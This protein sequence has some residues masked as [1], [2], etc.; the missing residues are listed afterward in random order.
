[1]VRRDVDDLA[2]EDFRYVHQLRA[3]LERVAHVQQAQFPLDVFGTGH[4]VH[5]Q[6][7]DE[8]RKL[9][10]QRFEME[11]L[12]AIVHA[13]REAGICVGYRDLTDEEFWV[14]G[15]FPNL[16]VMPGVVMCEAAAQLCSFFTQKFDLLGA[17]VVGFGGL[18]DVRFF[19]GTSDSRVIECA[20][21]TYGSP[22]LDEEDNFVRDEETGQIVIETPKGTHWFARE[23]GLVR[24]TNADGDIEREL[25]APPCLS[26]SFA[27]GCVVE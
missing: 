3:R 21:V 12:T 24:S 20:R 9:N 11:Q 1:M 16:P 15:H 14:R 23:I 13:D 6:R 25:T 26:S 19:R 8:I 27:G 2:A 18:E 22:L 10:P 5:D 4:V 17:K 7:I